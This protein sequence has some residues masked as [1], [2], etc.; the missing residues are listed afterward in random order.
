VRDQLARNPEAAAWVAAQMGV[1]AAMPTASIPADTVSP[2]VYA[3]LDAKESC[4]DWV[5][6]AKKCK[7]TCT[8]TGKCAGCICS[9]GNALQVIDSPEVASSSANHQMVEVMIEFADNL[10]TREHWVTVLDGDERIAQVLMN[11]P[12]RFSARGETFLP[13]SVIADLKIQA[14]QQNTLIAKAFSAWAATKLGAYSEG[15]TRIPNTAFANLDA[16]TSGVSTLFP[17]GKISRIGDNPPYEVNDSWC[18]DWV[19]MDKSCA[20]G[21]PSGPKPSCTGCICAGSNK[22]LMVVI[23]PEV[24]LSTRP[25]LR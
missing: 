25:D 17:G 11:G 18:G 3:E 15:Y 4:G 2:L 1:Y 21:C 14:M 12:K 16:S 8:G 6:T 7:G 23:G 19:K 24:A 20:P 13:L 5:S 22:K 9:K 10:E